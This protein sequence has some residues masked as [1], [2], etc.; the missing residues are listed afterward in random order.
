MKKTYFF[1]ILIVACLCVTTAFS[2]ILTPQT[3]LLNVEAAIK[4]AEQHTENI[5]TDNEA[6]IIWAKDYKAKQSPIAFVYLHGF[7][8][9]NREGEPIMSMLSK[10][11][12]ANVYLSRLKEHGLNR[13]D[14]YKNLTP[15]NYI[16]TTKEALEIGKL[17][18]KQIILVSTSTGGT[19]S[20]KLAS[21]DASI[22]GLVMY[23]PFIGLKNPAFNAILTPE[24]KAGFT[25]MNGGEIMKQNRG[26]AESKYWSTS[27]HIDGYEALIKMLNSTATV[28]TF[29][30]VKAPVFVGYYY[31]NEKEQ[32]QVVSVPAILNMYDNLGTPKDKKEK[33]AFPEAGNHVIACDLRSKDYM[34]VYNKTVDFIDTV[35]LE[36]ERLYNFELQGHRGARGLEPENTILAFKKALDLKVNTLELD[37]VITKDKKV[38]VSHEPWLNYEVTLDAKG[39]NITKED[40]LAFNIYKNKYKKLKQ[41]DVGS[42]GNPKFIKQEK[43]AAHKPLLSEVITYAEGINSEILYNIEIK[44]T[45]TD[46]ANGFQPSVNEFSDLLITEIKKA[47]LPLNRVV[48]Q[49]FDPRVLEYLHK[50][51]PDYTLSFLTY[52]NDFETNMNILSFVPEI[53]SPYYILLN[54]QEVKNIHAKN[55]KVFPWTVNTKDDMINVLKMGVDGIITDYPDIAL[56]LRQ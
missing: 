51:Y 22:A 41:Y 18:G 1:L 53:Y 20:L 48:I 26:E 55:M 11:Y 46:E 31:K 39:N 47:N 49:S 32:D 43:I 7:G 54:N 17:L 56:P 44:S 3:T 6:R 36:K 42:L 2:Q 45:P 25:Q 10:Q 33:V 21:E 16:A 19:L 12:N 28:E 38:V 23:S 52:E 24:G 27:Y 35:I 8:A 30:K 14:N 29:K 13:A 50:T 15:E 5:K 4:T 34:N 9:S 40:A 37:V